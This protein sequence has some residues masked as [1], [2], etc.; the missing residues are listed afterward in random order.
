MIN[1]IVTVIA[2]V[3]GVVESFK[4]IREELQHGASGG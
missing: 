3:L 4:V 2:V 1:K